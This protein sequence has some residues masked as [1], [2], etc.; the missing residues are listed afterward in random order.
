MATHATELAKMFDGKVVQNEYVQ[1]VAA[2]K[3]RN[4]TLVDG[5]T[6]SWAEGINLFTAKVTEKTFRF[7]GLS[8]AAAHDTGSVTV[9]DVGGISHEVPLD[10]ALVQPTYTD[11]SW[12]KHSVQVSRNRMTPHMWELVVVVRDAVLYMNGSV[13]PDQG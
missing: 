11:L 7:E 9:T 12:E 10:A 2:L 6:V 8:Y 13:A 3:W 5:V 4:E 1:S